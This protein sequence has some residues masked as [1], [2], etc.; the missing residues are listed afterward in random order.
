MKNKW[1]IRNEESKKN[2][3]KKMKQRTRKKSASEIAKGRIQK[4]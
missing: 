4:K 2:E 1:Y 3:R